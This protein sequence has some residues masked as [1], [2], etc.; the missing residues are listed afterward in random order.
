MQLSLA[1][2]WFMQAGALAARA[3][4]AGSEASAGSVA[5]VSAAAEGMSGTGAAIE[6][7][8][9]GGCGES[10]GGAMEHSQSFEPGHGVR[11]APLAGQPSREGVLA[12]VPARQALFLSAYALLLPLLLLCCRTVL[13]RPV[14]RHRQRQAPPMQ[15]ILMHGTSSEGGP[16]NTPDPPDGK[17]QDQDQ[18]QRGFGGRERAQADEPEEAA[19]SA[20]RGRQRAAQLIADQ[21]ERGQLRHRPRRR[22]AVRQHAGDVVLPQVPV[23][24]SDGVESGQDSDPGL[25]AG[26]G[27]MLG[28][29][30]PVSPTLR[31]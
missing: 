21:V 24:G 13:K 31:R 5:A 1:R 14:L 16:P 23:C 19:R 12:E 17:R 27:E 2:K 7:G 29:D 26:L 15:L 18:G 9:G 28:Q 8:D 30:S 10:G 25:A 20:P 22:P 4:E 11:V 3:E 6:Q